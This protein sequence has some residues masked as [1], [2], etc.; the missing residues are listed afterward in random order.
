MLFRSF[1]RVVGR[2]PGR[3]RT[4]S[5]KQTQAAADLYLNWF[6]GGDETVTIEGI[7]NPALDAGDVMLVRR[8]N[9]GIYEAAGIITDLTTDFPNGVDLS[10][11]TVV[12]ITTDYGNAI[13][14]QP[15]TKAGVYTISELHVNPTYVP[16]A[17]GQEIILYTNV[18]TNTVKV[19]EHCPV[20]SKI[21]PVETFHPNIQYL[22]GTM[23][24]DPAFTQYGGA[25]NYYIDQIT[26]PLNLTDAAQ[27]TA[28]ERRVGT[29]ED[30]ARIAEFTIGY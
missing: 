17:K 19:T 10:P 21:I 20:G 30:A 27:I 18:T 1:G 14:T 28:R 8:K 6:V 22:K 4:P 5:Q 9:V 7:C 15:P 11:S 26:I 23:I 16:L 25:V 29:K 2:E 12:P 13:D 3:K 24:L